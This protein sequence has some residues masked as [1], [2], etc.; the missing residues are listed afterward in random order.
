MKKGTGFAFFALAIVLFLLST[1][2][3][4]AQQAYSWA[5]GK[6]AGLAGKSSAT[7]L[8]VDS[9]DFV[10][11][12]GVFQ[13][14]LVIDSI[15]LIAKGSNDIFL[16]K[17]TGEGRL[18]WL[19]TIG[20]SSSEYSTFL[21]LGANRTLFMA[22]AFTKTLV[23]PNGDSVVPT[24]RGN[25][26][27]QQGAVLKFDLDGNV[28]WGS[29]M[30]EYWPNE[31]SALA[32][33]P[34]SGLLVAIK[35]VVDTSR[36]SYRYNANVKILSNSNGQIVGMHPFT[37]AGNVQI[38]SLLAH[39]HSNKFYVLGNY[40]A[41]QGY[42]SGFNGQGGIAGNEMASFVQCTS[43]VPDFSNP[44][45]FRFANQWVRWGGGRTGLTG[46]G[47][48]EFAGAVLD[49]YDNVTF[50]GRNLGA[51]T[52]DGFSTSNDFLINAHLFSYDKFGVR[53]FAKSAAPNGVGSVITSQVYLQ[54]LAQD[55]GG[56][57]W[58]AGQLAGSTT[59]AG[60]RVSSSNTATGADPLI[61]KWSS[62]GRPIS[63]QVIPKITMNDY[64]SASSL[65]TATGPFGDLYLQY[66]TN[67]GYRFGPFATPF[68]RPGNTGL[69]PTN[70]IK[71]QTK[72]GNFIEGKIIANTI[73]RCQTDTNTSP[74]TGITIAAMPGNYYGT[75]DAS[76]VYRIKVLAGNYS[77][78]WLKTRGYERD[79]QI[80][81]EP[82]TTYSV[83]FAPSADNVTSGGNN[84][85]IKRDT[86][87]N[88]LLSLGQAFYRRCFDGKMVFRCQNP[89]ASAINGLLVNVFLPSN[90]EFNSASLP[91]TYDTSTRAHRVNVGN[92]LP[93][94]TIFFSISTKVN[95]SS[96][97]GQQL[98]TYATYTTSHPC[99]TGTAQWDG[100]FLRP[101]VQCPK[102]A[103]INTTSANMTQKT[104][105]KIFVDGSL[106][107]ADS[108]QL[109]S[110]DS[111]VLRIPRLNSAFHYRIEVEQPR[112]NPF[113]PMSVLNKSC[114]NNAD[115]ADAYYPLLGNDDAVRSCGTII[116]SF[117]P[118]DKIAYPGSR[119]TI[120][121]IYPNTNLEYS[122]R[123]QNC[124]T[125]TAFKVSIT[126][127]L[128]AA[129][130]INSLYLQ[131]SSHPF[132][133]DILT[134]NVLKFT[135]TDILLPDSTTNKIGSN[136][137]VCFRIKPKAD[138]RFGT[139][140]NNA[141]YIY[142]DF[143][144]PIKTPVVAR[145]YIDYWEDSATIDTITVGIAYAKGQRCH[146]Y[147]N[148]TK[149]NLTVEMQ[150]QGM[151]VLCDLRGRRLHKY[152]L[153]P[154][155]QTVDIK[156]RV[157]GIYLMYFHTAHSTFVRQI[158]IE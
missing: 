157:A 113:E 158:R 28:L 85:S 36:F 111:L 46:S 61:V 62:T 10:Y 89:T 148:P 147:P 156:E 91:S 142:F 118:N 22:V 78:I 9:G 38:T 84:F 79:V 7:A 29:S 150:V 48:L 30:Q 127:S 51:F 59:I 108:L 2:L 121:E 49:Q 70:L 110:Q 73:G 115:M 154:G 133:L 47:G 131:G 15:S 93:F 82:S 74:I 125:D 136:G 42:S 60:T 26:T 31:V 101:K 4:Q 97:L 25:Y 23:L 1:K 141:A 21:T 20:T 122:I 123:F 68:V 53:R 104:A 152:L 87:P 35:H 105:Y 39:Q 44:P 94:Q 40:T 37:S 32:Y 54:T 76:G 95:C 24:R 135:F 65:N 83:A 124:G 92:L 138:T 55:L 155:T 153:H 107:R 106:I 98:C 27:F 6:T 33:K 3:A 103:F 8:V 19:K 109:Q 134:G 140:I 66:R 72:F 99:Q 11:E 137:F 34:E 56:N 64:A 120:P 117:D 102:V 130:D 14:T 86:C 116:G 50:L 146:L 17:R 112:G 71:Y 58:S 90:L 13:D 119:A 16:S 96:Q 145:R 151:A 114:T 45:L 81:P 18:V 149:G 12:A 63:A 126:D 129:L 88:V 69:V 57:F 52:F 75:S 80:C 100:S 77:L 5:W 67:F 143:N 128:S 41:R 132:A 139:I 43:L 144:N